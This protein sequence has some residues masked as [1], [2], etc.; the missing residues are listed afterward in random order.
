M[1]S[2]FIK[3]LSA[4]LITVA[5][6]YPFWPATVWVLVFIAPFTA[7]GFYDMFQKRHSIRRN[8]PL[9]G[10]GRWIMEE[11]RPFIR[12]YFV[13][14]D[15]D[16]APINRMFRNIVYQ[17]AKGALE[18]VPFG[19]RVDT[20]RTG[21]EWIGHSLSAIDVS[22]VDEDLRVNVGG[23][24]CRQPYSASIFNI[25]AM[26]FGALSQNAILALN[27]GAKSGEFAH[28][29][30]EGGI[31]PYH[32][33]H[34]GDLIWQIGTGYFGC[35]D[36]NGK[37]SPDLFKEKVSLES[38]K[39]IEIKLSQGAKPGHGGILPAGKN[40]PEISGIRG[41]E[42]YTQVNS[43]ATHNAFDSPLGL[44]Q[45]IAQLR[46]LSDGKPVGFK[47]SI[48]RKS[49]FVAICKAMHESGILADFITVDGGEGGTGA[50]PLEYT[51]SIGMP[52]REAIT[53]VADC[54]TGFGLKQHIKIIA[55]GKII[56]GFHLVKNMALGAD[57][58]NSAR[59][60]MLAVGCVHSLICNSNRCPSGVATQ[61]PRLFN[62][63]VVPDKA[64]RVT[65]Y[66][67]KTVHATAEII[68]STGIC[69]TSE[70]NRT[71]IYRR[72]SQYEIK[73]YDQIFPYLP[74]NC[75][76]DGSI[77]DLFKLIMQ[78][79]SS[80]TFA[81]HNCLTRIDNECREI[82]MPDEMAVAEK[83]TITED[84]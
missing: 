74:A 27:K 29:S 21:Y 24:D 46:E 34:G 1:H 42:P 17:R 13:E 48:G 16:G 43:P 78:E 64:A 52:L 18:T 2:T 26:S 39:M 22:D 31:S 15:T 28:N 58:C 8:F 32:L 73:R 23:P 47:L 71:H 41:V 55:S 80:D 20:Y 83:T 33:E 60:M 19:T 3:A 69:H 66:H 9:F 59:G 30:G 45:F 44:V 50:A 67:A 61:D 25:S 53:F 57:I 38:V 72:I 49:E 51:N 12:Q 14:S 75:L 79:A 65:H 6:I 4:T 76:L 7:L 40:T 81:P 82:D 37:F 70:L 36:R 35:R 10:R 68:A 77:P 84:R 62:G 54:L 5:I 63:L 11:I 56:T